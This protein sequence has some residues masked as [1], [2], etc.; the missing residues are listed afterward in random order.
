MN[1][2]TSGTAR[3]T[4]GTIFLTG[5]VR[6]AVERAARVLVVLDSDHGYDTVRA[7]L[8]AYSAFASRPLRSLSSSAV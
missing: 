1:R 7:E 8:E 4:R 6:A 5:K 2:H 3:G